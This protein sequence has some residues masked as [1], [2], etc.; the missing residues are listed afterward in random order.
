MTDKEQSYNG[1]YYVTKK[2]EWMRIT[3]DKE[4]SKKVTLCRFL[5]NVCLWISEFDGNQKVSLDK[6][7]THIDGL[8]SPGGYKEIIAIVIRYWRDIVLR[9]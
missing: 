1:L 7:E 3:N 9:K 5:P 8:K 6:R 4:S 2:N